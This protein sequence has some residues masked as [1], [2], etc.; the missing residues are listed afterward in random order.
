MWLSD[1]AGEIIAPVLSGHGFRRKG[2]RW[3]RR[4]DPLVQSVFIQSRSNATLV[5]FTINWAV[6]AGAAE[7]EGRVGLFTDP[8][9]DTWWKIDSDG[10]SFSTPPLPNYE[11]FPDAAAALGI[12]AQRLVECLEHLSS[13]EGLRTLLSTWGE[14]RERAHLYFMSPSS[15]AFLRAID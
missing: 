5:I 2:L 11:A 3:T 6:A 12:L 4:V 8:P 15:A 7:L 13:A 9:E 1:A 14:Q 10:I